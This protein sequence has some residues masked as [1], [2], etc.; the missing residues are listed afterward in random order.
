MT[1][2]K[3]LSV[4]SAVCAAT[5]TPRALRNALQAT[6]FPSVCPCLRI[7]GSTSEMKPSQSSPLFAAS[8]QPQA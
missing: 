3:P 8:A 7:S 6:V 5:R 2:R 1:L 4:R